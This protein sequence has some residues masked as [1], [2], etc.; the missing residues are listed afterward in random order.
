MFDIF[1][2]TRGNAPTRLTSQDDTFANFKE[3]R[4][5]NAASKQKGLNGPLHLLDDLQKETGASVNSEGGAKRQV[6]IRYYHTDQNGVPHE[7]TDSDGRVLWQASYRAWGDTQMETL[8]DTHQMQGLAD[9]NFHQ[10]L[11]FMGHYFDL[12]TGL[13][14]DLDRY[15]DPDAG[16]YVT[17]EPIGPSSALNPYQRHRR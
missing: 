7:L 17:P 6:A 3:A 10:P 4:A 8:G 15:Y 12:E 11:R 2:A 5:K 14:S 1:E 9:A 16:R 13:H